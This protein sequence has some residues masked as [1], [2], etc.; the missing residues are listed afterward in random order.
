MQKGLT[1][2]TSEIDKLVE[3]SNHTALDIIY[4]L[5]EQYFQKLLKKNI[6]LY[7]NKKKKVADITKELKISH[8]RFYKILEQENVSFTKYN[9]NKEK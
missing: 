3:N 8:K 2:I 9:K 1:K 4:E 5:K 7:T 6:E